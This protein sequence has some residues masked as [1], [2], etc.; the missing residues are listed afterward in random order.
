MIP[1][2]VL[3]DRG[4]WALSGVFFLLVF[5]GLLVPRR[6][7]RDRDEALAKER[8]RNDNLAEGLKALLTYAEA[9]DRILQ[10][11]YRSSSPPQPQPAP[12]PSRSDL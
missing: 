1:W 12:G 4:G 2:Q 8:Q 5:F 3:A 9:A 10:A 11:W 6:T 7:I